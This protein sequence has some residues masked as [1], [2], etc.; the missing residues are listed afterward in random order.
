MGYLS[1][2]KDNCFPLNRDCGR[3]AFRH[4]SVE[5]DPIAL[6]AGNPFQLS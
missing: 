3:K 4:G 6:L 1:T 5:N 2:S